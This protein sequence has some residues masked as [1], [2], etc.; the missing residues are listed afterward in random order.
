MG[1]GHCSST[2]SKSTIQKFNNMRLMDAA[3]KLTGN[4]KSSAEKFAK[5]YPTFGDIR[6]AIKS[7]DCNQKIFKV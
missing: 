2:M 4:L 6:K 3:N 1:Y 5:Q 7:L